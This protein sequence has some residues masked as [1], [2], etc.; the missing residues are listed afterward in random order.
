VLQASNGELL[1]GSRDANAVFT[2]DPGSGATR[3]LVESG[4]G[5][6]KGPAGLAFGPDGML[7]VSSRES[8]QILRF[9]AATGKPDPEPFI[10]DLADFPEFISLVTQKSV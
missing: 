8:K 9:D 4:A 1:V 6:L 2:I 7:Y 10:N 5:G 3:P